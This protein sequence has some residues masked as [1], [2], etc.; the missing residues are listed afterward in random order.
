MRREEYPIAL[1]LASQA[2]RQR[3]LIERKV[4]KYVAGAEKEAS[5][6]R[7]Q[8]LVLSTALA[9]LSTPPR[10]LTLPH[11]GNSIAQRMTGL[12]T[13]SRALV[14]GFLF[15]ALLNG[16]LIRLISLN[17]NL[18]PYQV[19]IGPS[20]KAAVDQVIDKCRERLHRLGGLSVDE[21]A[22]MLPA[23][24]AHWAQNTSVIMGHLLYLG[25]ATSDAPP[26]VG[27]D[28]IRLPH[29]RPRF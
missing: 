15:E 28:L 22:G 4:G 27:I 7:F 3:A 12:T 1:A 23:G 18:E 2:E 9:A 29:A 13:A 21:G 25:Y 6:E 10:L 24:L 20:H 17:R 14:E 19:V 5:F 26:G 8:D 11:L 16:S